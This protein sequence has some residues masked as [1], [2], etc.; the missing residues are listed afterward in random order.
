[1]SKSDED[2][3]GQSFDPAR[4]GGESAWSAFHDPYQPP[5][6]GDRYYSDRCKRERNADHHRV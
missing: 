6:Q 2:C 4:E 5:A 1:L 3:P